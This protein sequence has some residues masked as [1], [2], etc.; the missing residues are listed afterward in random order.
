MKLQNCNEVKI[1]DYLISDFTRSS[2]AKKNCIDN[3]LPSD[4]FQRTQLT[5]LTLTFINKITESYHSITSGYR[6]EELNKLAGGVENSLHKE[7]LA[8]DFLTKSTERDSGFLFKFKKYATIFVSSLYP[9]KNFKIDAYFID[10][11]EKTAIH[12]E[13]QPLS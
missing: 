1:G 12:F 3:S 5:L 2:L 13:I 10:K 4:L 8:I 6:C 9:D 11:V 7:A